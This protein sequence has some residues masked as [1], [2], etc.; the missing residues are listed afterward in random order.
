VMIMTLS[1]FFTGAG[2]D[3]DIPESNCD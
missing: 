2:Q 3:I 1:W